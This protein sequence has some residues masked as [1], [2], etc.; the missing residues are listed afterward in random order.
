MIDFL[1]LLA[2]QVRDALPVLLPPLLLWTA[3]ACLGEGAL[4]LASRRVHPVWSTTVRTVFVAA[5]PLQLLLAPFAARW[6]AQSPEVIQDAIYT[7][8]LPTISAPVIEQTATIDTVSLLIGALALVWFGGIVIG[9]ARTMSEA[10]SLRRMTAS[11]PKAS[12]EVQYMVSE[13]ARTAGIQKEIAVSLSD[14]HTPPY[15][16]GFRHP[17]I[18]VPEHLTHDPTALRLALEHEI[19]HIRHRDFLRHLTERL[20]VVLTWP[21]PLMHVLHRALALDRERLA[22]ANVLTCHPRDRRTYSDLLLSFA[23]RPIPQLALGATPGFS[24]LT[25]RLETMKRPILSLAHL[26]RT[27]SAARVLTTVLLG[28]FVGLGALTTYAQEDEPTPEPP[29]GPDEEGI[30]SVVEE[31]PVLVGGLEGL[32]KRVVYPEEARNAGI[33]GRVFLRFIVNEDGTVTNI[34]TTESPHPMLTEAAVNAI[35]NT[36]FEPGRHDGQAVKVRFAL[37]V[38]FWVSG[39]PFHQIQPPD[40]PPPGEAPPAPEEP[41]APPPPPAPAPDTTDY[42]WGLER[43]RS[44]REHLV[45]PDAAMQEGVEGTVLVRFTLNLDSTVNDIHVVSSPD[46]RLSEAAVKAL[47]ESQMP[48]AMKDGMPVKSQW[49]LP[50]NFSL[51]EEED[52]AD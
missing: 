22:D 36:V 31:Q 38:S 30:Y 44:F 49:T 12:S 2:D 1:T 24:Q 15:T 52:D 39:R 40:P 34:E 41:P 19:S 17:H 42:D 4:R 8:Q 50:V 21:H 16:F 43:F 27:R 33:V 23:S 29:V 35:E 26:N 45:Y 48:V 5:L 18:V 32:Q 20:I 25:T 9:L 47:E 37:P 3:V 10:F 13:I 11:L 7:L 6:F 46:Q 28:T 14:E 51:P